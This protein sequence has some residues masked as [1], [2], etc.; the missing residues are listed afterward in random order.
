MLRY[1]MILVI[2]EDSNYAIRLILK[3][4]INEQFNLCKNILMF[5]LYHQIFN[6]L[7][8]HPNFEHT[9][10]SFINQRC[11]FNLSQ[12]L[13]Q[14]IFH[15]NSTPSPPFDSLLRSPPSLPHH[16]DNTSN[17]SSI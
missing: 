1:I 12:S 10:C 6:I 15:P 17:I 16:N 9:I 14:S 3:K 8:I 13:E 4:L 7:S 11:I 5:N 2:K